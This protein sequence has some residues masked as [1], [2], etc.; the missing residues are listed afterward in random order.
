[1]N[2]HVRMINGRL[3]LRQPQ[4]E[5]LKILAEILEHLSLSK[6]ADLAQSLA[7]IQSLYPHVEDF[8]RDFPSLCFNL[9]TGVGKTCLLYTS[10]SPRD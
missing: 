4:W 9:A 6:D 5:S 3:S 1:M 8:E 7:S 10:P 2:Q